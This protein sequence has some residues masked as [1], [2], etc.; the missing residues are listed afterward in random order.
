[1][2][3]INKK[4]KEEVAPKLAKKFNIDNA[5]AIPTL[6]KIVINVG[7]GKGLNEKDYA[8]FIEGTLMK[9]AGQKPIR[10][11]AKKSISNFKIRIGQ[12]VGV[13]LT[14]RKEKMYDFFDK[15]VNIT[16]P[17]VRDF[18]GINRKIVDKAGNATI[19]IKEHIYFPEIKLDELEK[20]NGLEITIVTTA[21]NMAQGE[22]L[23]EELGFPFIKNN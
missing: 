10:T 9:I 17:R 16:F 20:I 13:K 4:Y 1:M 18:R 19:G 11:K 15:L 22:A 14:L 12:V 3:R 6:E 7:L 5:N 8:D 23:L 2:H 21:K